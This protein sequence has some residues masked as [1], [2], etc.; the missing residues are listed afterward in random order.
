MIFIF[1]GRYL[2]LLEHVKQQNMPPELAISSA[3]SE[4]GRDTHVVQRWLEFLRKITTIVWREIQ[5]RNSIKSFQK[6]DR[7]CGRLV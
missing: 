1:T 7:Y 3:V 4:M 5:R 2:L 6:I